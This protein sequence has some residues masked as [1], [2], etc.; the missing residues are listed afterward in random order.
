MLIYFCCIINVLKEYF[1]FNYEDVDECSI[2]VNN[3][4]VLLCVI[5]KNIFGSFNCICKFGYIGDGI[6]GKCKGIIYFYN[7][8][9]I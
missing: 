5:C 8:F 1:I 9:C 2:G 3:C 6:I 4:D 7:S